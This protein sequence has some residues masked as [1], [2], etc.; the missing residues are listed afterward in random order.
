MLIAP[1]FRFERLW[2]T[3]LYVVVEAWRP[4]TDDQRKLV[5]GVVPDD[6]ERVDRRPV[7]AEG[8]F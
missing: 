5:R 4:A 2:H 8:Q 7:L 6:V 1:R 3:F